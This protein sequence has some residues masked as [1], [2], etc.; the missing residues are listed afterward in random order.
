ME[1][2]KLSFYYDIGNFGPRSEPILKNVS[3][4]IPRGAKVG[5]LGKSGVGKSTLIKLLARLF[6]PTSGEIRIDG[7]NINNLDI[8]QMITYHAQ[9]CFVFNN[10][11]EW[12]LTIGLDPGSVT[13]EQINTALE[14]S[15]LL[16]DV[17]A[18]KFGTDR[19]V[20]PATVS[21]IAPLVKHVPPS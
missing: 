19:H 13:S 21:N 15:N 10:T 1:V 3:F 17:R 20:T 7:I 4:F 16:Q 2:R 11:L 14:R 6:H 18:G 5:I 9:E 8:R 12:N